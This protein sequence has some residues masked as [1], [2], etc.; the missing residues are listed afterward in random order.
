MRRAMLRSDRDAA[1]CSAF[2]GDRSRF[3]PAVSNGMDSRNGG[4]QRDGLLVDAATGVSSV[5]YMAAGA[6]SARARCRA[7]ARSQRERPLRQDRSEARFLR[8]NDAAARQTA[9]GTARAQSTGMVACSDPE[10]GPPSSH[11]PSDDGEARGPGAFTSMLRPRID[12]ARTR[13]RLSTR[14]TQV[15]ELVALGE[16]NKTIAQILRLAEVTVEAHLT[17]LLRKSGADSRTNLAVRVW[18]RALDGLCG[19]GCP[20]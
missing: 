20:A 6:G 12:A 14:Q 5:S 7:R 15:L 2:R 13:W 4:D 9:H 18:A 1:V 8:Q 10:A 16:S 19:P 17:A 11:E 3:V